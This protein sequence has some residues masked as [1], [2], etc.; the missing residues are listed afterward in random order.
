MGERTIRPA[1]L[2]AEAEAHLLQAEVEEV[3]HQL[4]EAVEGVQMHPAAAGRPA[5][6]AAEEAVL[7]DQEEYLRLA[8]HH[9]SRCHRHVPL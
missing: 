3:A 2:E 9:F 7:P 1:G 5:H 4:M 6:L 8:G